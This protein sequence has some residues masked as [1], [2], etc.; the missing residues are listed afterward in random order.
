L[1][2]IERRL[3]VVAIAAVALGSVVVASPAGATG[4]SKGGPKVTITGSKASDYAFS[5]ATVTVAAGGKVHWKWSSNA[6][7]NVTFKKLGEASDDMSS[8][9]YTL[10][11]KKAGTYK[12]EC[13]IHDFKG[14]VVVN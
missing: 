4:D 14:K 13:T 11:F 8:G 6:P 10:K 3:T 9:S 12:Y 1:R 2:S 5:P 7:H